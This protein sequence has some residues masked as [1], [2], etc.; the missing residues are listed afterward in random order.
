VQNLS[1]VSP[2]HRSCFRFCIFLFLIIGAIATASAQCNGDS[3]LCSRRFD[4]VCFLYTHNAYNIKGDHR[5]PN[6][7]LSIAEQLELGVRG[8]MLDVYWKK[9]RAVLYHGNSI[10]GKR[11]LQADLEAIRLFLETHPHEI[12]SIIFESN[13]SPEQMASEMQKAGLL[14]HLHTQNP[15]LNWPTLQEMIAAGHRLVIFSEKDRGNPYPWLHHI[16]D[17]TT[18]NRYSNH[19]RAD[20]DTRY[21]R[22]DSANKQFL[23]NHFITHRKFGVGLKDSALVANARGNVLDHAL[24]V[25]SQTG[26][27]P[28]FVA[29]DFVESGD[30]KAA[31][32]VLNALWQPTVHSDTCFIDTLS[33]ITER[34]A[35]LRFSVPTTQ[36]I[37]LYVRDV[38]TG[39]IVSEISR[40]ES[41]L[42]GATLPNIDKLPDG[43]YNLELRM[44][45]HFERRKLI[46]RR[47]HL[48]Q[49]Y[50][51]IQ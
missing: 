43:Q 14:P 39:Q 50:L 3:I 29:V 47:T 33:M 9:D 8:M 4:Q 44:G 41:G 18:E 1:L 24:D 11:P 7:T 6:Q 23:L 28:N 45:S 31:V 20:F 42:K 10:L 12:L 22:G 38:I 21:N 34:Q 32:D 15:S 35:F 25:W 16:W 46:I 30:A 48:R 27:F 5:L 17:F 49:I 13:I 36:P 37:K 51:R 40:L 26:H 19:S 2:L